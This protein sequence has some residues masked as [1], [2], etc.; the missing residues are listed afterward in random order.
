RRARR[1]WAKAVQFACRLV[2]FFVRTAERPG[3]FKR[4]A[5]S[6][7]STGDRV[8]A[9]DLLLKLNDAEQQGLCRR[10]TARNVNV[11]GND[12]VAAPHDR[13]RIVVVAAA[14]R[15]GSHG[16]DPARLRHLVV[17]LA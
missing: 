3:G 2:T 16:Y 13:I 6:M 15:A 17:H 9:L 11:D 10:R 7:S 1:V 5:Q 4:T 14:V 12:T 8:G